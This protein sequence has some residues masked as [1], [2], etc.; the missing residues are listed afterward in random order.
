M[1]PDVPED[2]SLGVRIGWE[3]SL[4]QLQC[5]ELDIYSKDI[6]NYSRQANEK[7]FMNKFSIF[8][9]FLKLDYYDYP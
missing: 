9:V 1:F 7:Y 3:G 6:Q 4:N 8:N 2:N 5:C